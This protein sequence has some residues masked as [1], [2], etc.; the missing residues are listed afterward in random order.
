LSKRWY[1]VNKVID[2]ERLP[3]VVEITSGFTVYYRNRTGRDRDVLRRADSIVLRKLGQ[4]VID[5]P[6][7]SVVAKGIAKDGSVIY[8]VFKEALNAE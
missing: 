1:F 7:F 3:F 8:D 2:D 5:I 4:I 6:P